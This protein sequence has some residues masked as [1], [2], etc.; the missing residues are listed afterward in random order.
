MQNHR[1]ASTPSTIA[2]KLYATIAG[3]EAASDAFLEAM[4]P[5]LG[6]DS[7]LGEFERDL[8]DWGA[9]FGFAYALAR[10]ENPWEDAASVAQRARDAAWPVWLDWSG[11]F[12]DRAE[13][14]ANV[15]EALV[16][17]QTFDG[18]FP[19]EMRALEDALI[20]LWNAQGT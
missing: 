10:M 6:A 5:R 15:K 13:I 16:A 11:P 17:Y 19:R 7:H 1:T 18:Q 20:G 14:D 4:E 2:Q 9:A 12:H 8:L 3:D